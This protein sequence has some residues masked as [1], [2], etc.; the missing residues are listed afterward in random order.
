MLTLKVDVCIL[1]TH[2][3]PS[4]LKHFCLFMWIRCYCNLQG[5]KCGCAIWNQGKSTFTNLEALW[6]DETSLPSAWGN[7]FAIAKN[8]GIWWYFDTK[9]IVVVQAVSWLVAFPLQPLYPRALWC[10][11]QSTTWQDS[12]PI[13]CSHFVG[14][15]HSQGT[16]IL[17]S[18]P[19]LTLLVF[20]L[21]WYSIILLVGSILNPLAGKFSEDIRKKGKGA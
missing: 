11:Q 9:A 5:F 18:P 4:T 1:I 8:W 12:K 21:R 6:Q 3:L 10:W 15:N 19:C 20:L 2:H 7:L 14:Q 16:G 17:F 13:I